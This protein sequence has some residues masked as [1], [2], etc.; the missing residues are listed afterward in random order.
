MIIEK[1]GIWQVFSQSI[2]MKKTFFLLDL[3][4]ILQ[5]HA[6]A[7]KR[8]LLKALKVYLYIVHCRADESLDYYLI[9]N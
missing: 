5:Q 9:K 1:K 3:L 8:G 6:F 4:S 7:K 2:S